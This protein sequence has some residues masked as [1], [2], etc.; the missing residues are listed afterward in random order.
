MPADERL[1]RA[2]LGQDAEAFDYLI[3]RQKRKAWRRFFPGDVDRRLARRLVRDHWRDCYENGVPLLVGQ[4]MFQVAPGHYAGGVEIDPDDPDTEQNMPPSGS[5]VI[6]MPDATV[7]DIVEFCEVGSHNV[8]PPA[9]AM[10]AT[11]EAMEE[12]PLKQYMLEFLAQ[13]QRPTDAR[14]RFDMPWQAVQKAA[15]DIL[16]IAPFAIVFADPAGLHAKAMKRLTSDQAMEIGRIVFET[17]SE[18]MDVAVGALER[19]GLPVPQDANIPEMA[20]YPAAIGAYF[21]AI[22]GFRMWWD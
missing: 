14:L 9:D 19:K 12:G 6:A 21:K 2:V 20:D 17:N 15:S 3:G 10:R 7:L 5:M 16:Q 4:S 1:I 8:P 13:T 18:I 22:N 11:A